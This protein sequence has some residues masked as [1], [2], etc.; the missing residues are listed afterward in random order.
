MS[1][2]VITVSWG[3]LACRIASVLW[4]WLIRLLRRLLILGGWLR[5]RLTRR[6]IVSPTA[7]RRTMELVI[8]YIKFVERLLGLLASHVHTSLA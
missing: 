6:I 4:A 5:V 7:Q 3:F 8:V 2:L 1:R